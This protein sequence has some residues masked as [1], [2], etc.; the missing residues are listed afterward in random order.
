MNTNTIND[1][2]VN[3]NIF[4][5]VEPS[6]IFVYFIIFCVSIIYFRNINMTLGILFG[7]LFASICIYLLYLREVTTLSNSE[8]LHKIKSE[9]IRPLSINI[10]KYDDFTDF[11]FSIQ[12]LYIY[13]P[14]AYENMINALDTFIEIYDDVLLDNSLAGEYYSIAETRKELALN[15]LQSIIIMAPANK[16]VTSKI[17]ESL[18]IFEELFNKYLTIIYDQNNKYI[19]D[20]GY[21]NNTKVI[22]LN[23]DAYNKYNSETYDQYY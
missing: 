2:S 20:K 1:L 17:N 9:N 19:K 4:K 7:I 5:F 21:F 10:S 14:Q 8:Q 23:I 22:E 15:N 18:K 11:I 12:D 16:K 13:N 3:N 6:S